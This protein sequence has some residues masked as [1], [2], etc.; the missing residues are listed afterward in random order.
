MT[1]EKMMDSLT[2]TLWD[3]DMVVT[4]LLL[5]LS[6]FTW[7][8]LLLWPGPTFGRPT[9]NHMAHVMGEEAWAV[10]FF[11]S[12][13]TQ[14]TIVI[15]RDFHCRLARY[16]A[17]WN[18]VLWVFVVVSMLLSVYPPPAAI[19]AEIV[20]SLAAVWIWVRPYLLARGIEHARASTF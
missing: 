17:A 1:T 11:L 16:F 9:Y 2:H 14:V 15:R 10:V 19:S 4:R 18:M 13:A 20:L 12:A 6:E 5:G 8:L 3:T 7:F